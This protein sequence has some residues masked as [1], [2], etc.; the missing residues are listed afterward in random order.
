MTFCSII[1][2][3]QGHL[4]ADNVLPTLDKVWNWT[5]AT[6]AEYNVGIPKNPPEAPEKEQNNALARKSNGMITEAQQRRLF[7]IA[8]KA[9]LSTEQL[10]AFLKEDYGI[11]STKEIPWQQYNEICH[12]I[13]T[14]EVPS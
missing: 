13:E 10:K 2:S 11:N 1:K 5:R 7:A 12:V 4:T 8:N 3:M 9:K 6:L 14:G